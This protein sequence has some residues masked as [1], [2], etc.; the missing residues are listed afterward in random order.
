[1]QI[2]TTKWHLERNPNDT[3]FT[4]LITSGAVRAGDAYW[5]DSEIILT[6]PF[7]PEPTSAEQQRITIRLVT[8]DAE[9]EQ[10]YL[11]A[12]NA[13]QGNLQY[14]NTTAGQVNTS[15]QTIRDDTSMTTAE[16]QT[17]LRNVAQAVQVVSNQ[18][19]ELS[20]Q[21]NAVILMVLRLMNLI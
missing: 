5:D 11:A 3:D 7:S 1:M 10:N 16:V 19:V 8:A 4:D 6:I 12:L 14:V 9:E 20:R 18:Q 15:M 17:Y 13:R 2:D 21:N